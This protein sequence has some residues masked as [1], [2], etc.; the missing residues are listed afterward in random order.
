MLSAGHAE[1]ALPQTAEATINC[2]II[3]GV[4]PSAV[5]AQLKKVIANPEIEITSVWDT[6]WSSPSDLSLVMPDVEAVTTSMWPGVIVVPVMSTGGT[7]GTFLRAEGIPTFGVSG[8]F[9]DVDDNRQHGKDE[10]IGVKQYF[11]AQEFMYRLVKKIAGP[12]LP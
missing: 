11:E 3:P 7:D 2:R 4:E 10:R 6:I 5:K 9:T 8:I 12:R 1:N